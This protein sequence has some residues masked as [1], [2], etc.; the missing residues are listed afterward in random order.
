MNHNYHRQLGLN[1][2]GLMD[3]PVI[4]SEMMEAFGVVVLVETGQEA[5]SVCVSEDGGDY[6]H[7]VRVAD[8]FSFS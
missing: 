8:I 2:A 6:N 5:T 1:T 4:V 7:G 3:V